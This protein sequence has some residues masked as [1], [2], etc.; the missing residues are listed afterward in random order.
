MD[1]AARQLPPPVIEA[2][3]TKLRRIKALIKYL[4]SMFST[5]FHNDTHTI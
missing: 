4:S 5:A 1:S 2:T 3:K